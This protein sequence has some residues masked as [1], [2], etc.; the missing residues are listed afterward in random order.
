VGL[1][2]TPLLPRTAKFATSISGFLPILGILLVVAA[3][4]YR[5]RRGR[6]P[7]PRLILAA[8]IALGIA[9]I[10]VS[11]LGLIEALKGK[12][13]A[14]VNPF[15]QVPPIIRTV[16]EQLPSTWATFF[17]D[18]RFLLFLMLVGLYFVIRRFRKE[19]LLLALLGITSIYVASS[20]VRLTAF[21]DIAVSLIGGAGFT[22][23]IK[24]FME[25]AILTEAKKGKR[26]RSPMKAYALISTAILVALTAPSIAAN[27]K[28]ANMP[29]VIA[30]LPDWRDALAWMR[31]NLP[32]NAV[33]GSWWDSLQPSA[34]LSA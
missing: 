30:A 16:G 22:Y 24:R 29:P 14:I 32:Q 18:Y 4:I 3:E 15:A 11:Q 34:Q 6:Y 13:L 9:G 23:L 20:F 21:T 28:A 10:A 31:D 5:Y 2:V 25:A 33:V 1:A 12:F 8:I 7:Q 17:S 26:R 19:D 27:V